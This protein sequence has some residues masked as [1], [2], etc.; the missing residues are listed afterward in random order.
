MLHVVQEGNSCLPTRQSKHSK[1]LAG[2]RLYP[3]PRSLSFTPT[4]P[5]L[6][7]H[8]STIYHLYVEG[9]NLVND[10]FIFLAVEMPLTANTDCTCLVAWTPCQLSRSGAQVLLIYRY[11]KPGKQ[12]CSLIG[13]RVQNNP[14]YYERL[15]R[16]SAAC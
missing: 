13:Q 11:R 12:A 14:R 9:T 3:A 16:M 15:R 5:S 7:P 1:H 8:S 6:S 2:V 10:L 4:W